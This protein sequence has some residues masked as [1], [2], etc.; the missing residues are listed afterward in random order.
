M[1]KFRQ[2]LTGL[3]AR[4]TIMAGFFSLTFLFTM[5]TKHMFV[6]WNCIRIKGEVSRD[7]NWLKPLGSFSTNRCFKAVPLLPFFFV[8]YENTP[9]QI[10]T[11]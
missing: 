7:Y 3:S 11:L 1:G 9:I 5:R 6:I 8:H 4:D 2:C 10:Y